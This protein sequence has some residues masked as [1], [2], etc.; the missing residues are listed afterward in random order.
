M[1]KILSILCAYYIRGEIERERSRSARALLLA[2]KIKEREC[3]LRI[4]M[5]Y[6]NI[7]STPTY[8]YTPEHAMQ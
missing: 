6:S 8:E 5:K 3:A 4:K 7:I 1:K 2:I